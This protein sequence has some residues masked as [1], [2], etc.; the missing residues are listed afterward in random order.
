LLEQR[1]LSMDEAIDRVTVALEKAGA[2]HG[3]ALLVE[4]RA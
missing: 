3:Q 1:G 2:V 4:A